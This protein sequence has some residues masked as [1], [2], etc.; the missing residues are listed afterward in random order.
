MRNNTVFAVAACTTSEQVVQVVVQK[1][2]NRLTLFDWKSM[3][4]KEAYK[5]IRKKYVT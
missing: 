3:G 2:D 4:G 1:Q 5:M